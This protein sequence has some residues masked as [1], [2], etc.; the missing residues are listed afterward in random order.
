MWA[1]AS[2]WFTSGDRVQPITMP[3]RGALT[4][5]TLFPKAS[6]VQPGWTSGSLDLWAA[7]DDRAV[8]SHWSLHRPYPR[9]ARLRPVQP[10]RG[11][12]SPA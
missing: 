6:S 12:C 3:S 4:A 10:H 2:P 9:P 8:L 1:T 7:D 5:A 11:T